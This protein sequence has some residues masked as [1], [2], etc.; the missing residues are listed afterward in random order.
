MNNYTDDMIYWIWLST[1]LGAGCRNSSDIIDVCKSDPKIIYDADENALLKMGVFK[2]WQIEKLA[3]KDLTESKNIYDYCKNNGVD[4]ISV[5]NAR[6]PRLLTKLESCPFLLYVLGIMPDFSSKISVAMV[7]TRSMSNVA[8]RSAYEIAYDVAKSNIIITSGM[9]LGV[10]GVCHTAALDAGGTTIA[11]LGC[12]IDIVYPAQHRGLM[13]DIIRFGGAV[14]SEFAPGT[15]PYGSNFIIRN[16]LI[17]GLS[18]GTLIVEAGIKSGALNTARHTKEQ[19]RDLFAVPGPAGEYSCMGSNELLKSGAKAVTE[20][21]DIID[22]YTKRYGKVIDFTHIFNLRVKGSYSSPV[23]VNDI[24]NAFKKLNKKKAEEK[25]RPNVRENINKSDE[26]VLS[27]NEKNNT[28]PSLNTAISAQIENYLNSSAPIYRTIYQLIKE[29][30]MVADEISVLV[31]SD[32]TTVLTCLT[33]MEIEGI[34]TKESG[35][36]FTISSKS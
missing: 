18:V 13:D 29:K 6:F 3:N 15:R 11:V 14:I 24:N 27:E 1:T 8:K 31:E 4:I 23:L 7:G 9:A 10:D 5:N 30:S 35:G 21:G 28:S 20:G 17:S 16:R 22:F 25:D 33:L 36:K 12:G 26:T 32:V 19:G 34:V 2:K